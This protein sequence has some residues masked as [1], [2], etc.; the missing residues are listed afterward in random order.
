MEIVKQKPIGTKGSFKSGAYKCQIAP[1][2]AIVLLSK[3]FI[4]HETDKC[5]VSLELI[6]WM[7]VCMHINGKIYEIRL[8]QTMRNQRVWANQ[9][10]L[11]LVLQTIEAE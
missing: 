7:L 2:L 11:L 1:C 3:L 10:F 5:M 9:M 8:L 4:S 6:K